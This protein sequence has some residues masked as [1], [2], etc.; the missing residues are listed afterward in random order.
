MKQLRIA[1]TLGM[2]AV[3]GLSACATDEFGNTVRSPT[4]RKV[5]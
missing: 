4:P 1:I 2:V 5:R 3:F